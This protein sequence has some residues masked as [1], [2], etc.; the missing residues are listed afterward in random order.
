[1]RL[2]HPSTTGGR[3]AVGDCESWGRRLRGPLEEAPMGQQRD[4]LSNS[5]NTP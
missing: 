1:M 4:K 2:G 5:D 3:E